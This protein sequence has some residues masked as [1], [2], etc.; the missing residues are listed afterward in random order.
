MEEMKLLQASADAARSFLDVEEMTEEIW[1]RFVKEA[2]VYPD[3]RM[4]I[5]WKFDD[6]EAE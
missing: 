4:E 6:I 5:H 2:L 1:E 3:G